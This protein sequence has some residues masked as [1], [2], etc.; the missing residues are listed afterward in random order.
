MSVFLREK[1]IVLYGRGGGKTLRRN[2]G[3]NCDQNILYEKDL[4]YIYLA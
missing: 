2:E 3:E 4:S 1:G